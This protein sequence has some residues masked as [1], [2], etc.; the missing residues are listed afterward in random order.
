VEGLPSVADL[1]P[2]CRNCKAA[3]ASR[4]CIPL[5][6]IE[7]VS[8]E[9]ELKRADCTLIRTLANALDWCGAGGFDAEPSV[10]F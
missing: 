1:I 2:K 4:T 6:S 8:M 10:S 5:F 7:D 9:D 3:H